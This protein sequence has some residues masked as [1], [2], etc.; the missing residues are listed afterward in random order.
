MIDTS[1]E[2]PLTT[3]CMLALDQSHPTGKYSI[4]PLKATKYIIAALPKDVYVY[5]NGLRIQVDL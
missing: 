3:T 5:Q 2:A 4:F 1:P